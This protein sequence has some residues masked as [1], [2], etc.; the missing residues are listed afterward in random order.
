M[1]EKNI[2]E[3]TFLK[4]YQRLQVQLVWFNYADILT[5]STDK[6]D[7]FNRAWFSNSVEGGES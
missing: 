4:T 6:A 3:D 5:S 1:G 2:K 7:D